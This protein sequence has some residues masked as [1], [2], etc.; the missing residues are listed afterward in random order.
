MKVQ[1]TPL[2]GVLLIEPP[3]IF[4]DFRGSYVELYNK[5]LYREAGITEEF[6]QDDIS[7]SHKNVLRGLH[8]DYRTTKLVTCLRGSFHLA[9]VNNNRDAAEYRKSTS[10][11]LSDA[12][13]LQVLIPP[14]FANGHVVLSDFAIFHYKQ[15][16]TY[17]RSS[18]FTILWNDPSLKLSWPVEKPILSRRDSGQE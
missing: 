13:R 7:T 11:V 15:T 3:T 4:E 1:Q 14:G 18:Q 16:T 5:D 17:D 10:F 12:N 2:K 9:V 6:V 8:G